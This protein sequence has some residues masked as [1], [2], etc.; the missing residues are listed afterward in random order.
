M[1]AL[2]HTRKKQCSGVHFA[3][4]FQDEVHIPVSALAEEQLLTKLV[5]CTISYYFL[6]D[7]EKKT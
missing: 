3:M 4:P 5:P 2:V 6:K 1:P 7:T